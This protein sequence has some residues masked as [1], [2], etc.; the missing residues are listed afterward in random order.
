MPINNINQN[1]NLNFYYYRENY[2]YNTYNYNISLPH[3][4]YITFD[5]ENKNSKSTPK[6]N[7]SISSIK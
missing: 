5:D 7:Q 1:F 6:Q 3:I 2:Y 4:Y